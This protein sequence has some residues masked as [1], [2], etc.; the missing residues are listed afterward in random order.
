MKKDFLNFV[1]DADLAITEHVNERKL[2]KHK[3]NCLEVI[4]SNVSNDE[5]L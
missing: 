2:N 3:N 1:R 5:Q 4:H